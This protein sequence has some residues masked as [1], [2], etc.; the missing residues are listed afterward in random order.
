MT[1]DWKRL[2]ADY[3]STSRKS[4]SRFSEKDMRQ[5]D[6]AALA[7]IGISVFIDPAFGG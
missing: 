2:R 1:V 6:R 4:A 5:R 3:L 7:G